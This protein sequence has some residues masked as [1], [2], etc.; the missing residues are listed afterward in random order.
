MTTRVKA[1][2]RPK[3]RS[4]DG[5]LFATKEWSQVSQQ[6]GLTVWTSDDDKQIDYQFFFFFFFEEYM[7]PTRKPMTGLEARAVWPRFMR[8]PAKVKFSVLSI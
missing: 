7:L 6:T 4:C 8:F 5:K 1:P 2:L 3:S